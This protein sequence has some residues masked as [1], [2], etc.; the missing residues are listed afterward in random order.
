MAD[1]E[2]DKGARTRFGNVLHREAVA[3]ERWD[4]PTGRYCADSR[5]VA[6]AI[7]AKALGFNV[8]SLD[9]GKRSCPYH[10]HHLEEELFYVL[11][12]R[13]L[14]RQGDTSGEEI[15]EVRAGDF[16]SFP[17]GTGVAHQFINDGET[18]LVYLAVSNRVD[19]DVA[20]YPDSN[21]VLLRR[22][23][24]MLRREPKLDYFDG[25]V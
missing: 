7:G 9:P 18:P 4:E 25:E 3:V 2:H 11:E 8:T 21:K 5:E 13:G 24:L 16:I 17:A 15:V 22:T 23:R 19:G 12:G 14:L 10:F 6:V 1:S 20:E